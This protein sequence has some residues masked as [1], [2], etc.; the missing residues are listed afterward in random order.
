MTFRIISLEHTPA[1]RELNKG[2]PNRDL[3]KFKQTHNIVGGDCGTSITQTD[4]RTLLTVKYDN[5]SI[6]RF[7]IYTKLTAISGGK[8]FTDK[9]IAELCNKLAEKTYTIENGENIHIAIERALRSA[10]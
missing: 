1:R 7:N 5:G 9:F 6:D 3:P 8:R 4:G 10:V 2:V